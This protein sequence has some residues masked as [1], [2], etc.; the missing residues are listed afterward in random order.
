MSLAHRSRRFWEMEELGRLLEKATELQPA[1][2]PSAWVRHHVEAA[3]VSR[4]REEGL[5]AG[6][7]MTWRGCRLW[8]VR[9]FWTAAD[10]SGKQS[11]PLW[12]RTGGGRTSG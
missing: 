8:E 11:R 7:G 1:V 2:G 5:L 6:H 9:E 12:M 10:R 3:A 4:G